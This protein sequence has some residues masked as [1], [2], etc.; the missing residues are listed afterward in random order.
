VRSSVITD[1]I[2]DDLG[3]ALDVCE[4]LGIR[5]VELRSVG[6]RNVVEHDEEPLAAMR[7][8]LDRRGFEVCAVASPFLKCIRDGSVGARVGAT[9]GAADRPHADQGLVLEQALRAAGILGASIVRTFSFWREDEPAAAFPVLGRELHEASAAASAAG[10]T[11][12]IE[13]ESECNVGTGAEL[14]AVLPAAPFLGVIWD[15]ANAAALGS[16]ELPVTVLERTV[17]VHVKDVDSTGD[18]VRVGAG[19]VDQI[20]LLRT[21]QEAGYDGFL[22]IE[23]HYEKDGSREAATRECVAALRA[24]AGGAGVA[25]TS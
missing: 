3:H 9:H 1:E 20:A 13:N 24:I 12:A 7:A 2:S 21:L 14:A 6:G 19:L 16:T 10:L 15:P 5:A 25:L 11:L 8:E 23:T 4:E 22:S 17:H 18:C